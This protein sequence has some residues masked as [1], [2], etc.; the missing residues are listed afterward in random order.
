MNRVI[1]L[2]TKQNFSSETNANKRVRSTTKKIPYQ[3]LHQHETKPK[4]KR[5][6]TRVKWTATTHKNKSPRCRSMERERERF[7][8]KSLYMVSIIGNKAPKN[9]AETCLRV[10]SCRTRSYGITK[11]VYC[12]LTSDSALICI[13]TIKISLHTSFTKAVFRY[14]RIYVLWT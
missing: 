4:A 8:L 14:H 13:L 12:I 10:K 9:R 1:V 2:P 7:S 6:A 3:L 11:T 5:I